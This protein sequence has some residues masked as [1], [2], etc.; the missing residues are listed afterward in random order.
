MKIVVLVKQVPDTWGERRLDPSTGRLD[1]GASDRIIDE[2]GERALE[3]ALTHKDGA[4]DTEVVALTMGPAPATDALRKALAMGA[5]AAVHVVDDDLAG[6]DLLRTARV[7]AAALRIT[8]YDLVIA[9]NES[10]D[11]RSGVVPAMVAELLSVPALLNLNAM[12]L[13]PDEVS[14]DRASENGIALVRAPLPALV[15]VS[16]RSADPRFPNLRGVMGAKKK[17][18][19]TLTLADLDEVGAGPASVVL[20][21]KERPARTAGRIVVD[22]GTGVAQLVEFLAAQRLI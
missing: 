15:S 17:P 16:E 6:A 20:T 1:R 9:G 4:K 14:G 19:T 21:S 11:G 12:E 13:R 18:V 22:D 2:I 10:T 3:A 8:G 5:D 7:L